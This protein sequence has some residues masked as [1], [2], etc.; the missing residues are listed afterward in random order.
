MCARTSSPAPA[1]DVVPDGAGPS[2][3]DP[4]A[5]LC[6][7]VIAP[8]T[9]SRNRHF[10]LFQDAR[11]RRARRRALLVRSLLTALRARGGDPGE[12]LPRP[13]PSG[14]DVEIRFEVPS[15]GLTRRTKLSPIELAL[16]RYLLQVGDDEARAADRGMVER[17]LS[18]LMARRGIASRG[19]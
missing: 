7:L 13:D 18:A 15:M 12:V 11:A 3:P 1:A 5:L 2:I 8:G 9:W 17:A 4:D 14:D 10:H 6:G 16:V 19:T